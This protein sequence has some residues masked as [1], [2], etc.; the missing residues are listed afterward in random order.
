MTNKKS[1][2]YYAPEMSVLGRIP[3]II[4]TSPSV[5]TEE[6]TETTDINW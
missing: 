6:F 4:C 3:G 1:N 2:E 5:T